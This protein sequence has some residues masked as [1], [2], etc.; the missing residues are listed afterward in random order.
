MNPIQ[1][2]DI[3]HVVLRV[4][5][6]VRS[7]VFYREVLGCR[8]ERSLEKLGLY[9]LRAGSSLIDLVAV[10]GP[11]GRLGGPPAGEQARNVDHFALFL[12]H[13]DDAAIRDHLAAHQV[14]PSDTAERYGARGMGPSLYI[15]DPD[16]NTIELKGPAT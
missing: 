13:F 15:A 1:I 14:E 7:L 8:E 9:Q 12:E 3:D 16:G 10:E 11:L 5:D 6:P 4:S 2:R